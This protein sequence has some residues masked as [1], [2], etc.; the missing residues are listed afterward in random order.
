MRDALGFDVPDT[1]LPLGDTCGL[2]APFFLAP[3][4][5]VTLR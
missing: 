2:L 3:R 4:R 1:L 5:V